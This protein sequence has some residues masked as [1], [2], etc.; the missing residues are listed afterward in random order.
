MMKR[1]LLNLAV[2]AA[3]GTAGAT[4]M[5]VPYGAN[6]AAIEYDVHYSGAT[7]SAQFVRNS[8]IDRACDPA[9][10]KEIT[11]Y[12]KDGDDYVV[13]CQLLPTLGGDTVRHIKQGGGSGDGTTPVS[14]PAVSPLLYPKPAAGFNAATACAAPVN[15]QTGAGTPF[16]FF[17]ACNIPNVTV[18]GGDIGTSDLEPKL[19]FDVNTPSTG[20]P[21]S[22]ADAAALDVK[23]LAGLAFGLPMTVGLRNA[24]QAL[25][26]PVGHP[27][28]PQDA[29]WSELLPTTVDVDPNIP[30]EEVALDV[31]RVAA[32]TKNPSADAS[33]S[34]GTARVRDSEL[35]M[36]NM[37]QAEVAGLMTGRLRNWSQIQRNGTNLIAAATAAGL[38]VPTS[39]PVA[40]LN[41]QRVHVCRRNDGSG[42]QAQFNAYFLARPCMSINGT[43]TA[44][45]PL[46]GG[47]NTCSYNGNSVVCNNRGSSDVSRCLDDLDK[48][49]TTSGLFNNT[50][51]NSLNNSRF[52][53]AIG[54]QSTE[55]NANLGF[56]F[57]FA[58]VDGLAPTINN[59]HLADYTDHYEQTCQIRKSNTTV[60]PNASG[61]V[62]RQLWD[63]V[64][65]AGPVDIF[66]ANLNF[67]HP[68]GTGGWLSVPLAAAG[69]AANPDAPLSSSLLMDPNNPLPINSW[70]R[71]GESCSAPVVFD[72]VNATLEGRP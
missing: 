15:T 24:L 71:R 3:L 68:W 53:W 29:E 38:P 6:D 56:N 13:V 20:I 35:C 34:L 33:P 37:T 64:C 61:A 66:E 5:A 26:F 12:Q 42:T 14:Q 39:S 69:T 57:R 65:T 48:N 36:P 28:H 22:A 60:D 51:A 16:V 58:K 72:A 31:A 49:A 10:A 23:P 44:E 30:G 54:V 55:V 27:C 17:N 7:A 46:S 8:L 41:N 40:P 52:A 70:T 45:S 63:T 59:V 25:Q 21:F 67:L 32:G 62:V 2:A 47:A 4:A 50:D 9:G 1:K 18:N 19:F 11:V 43:F